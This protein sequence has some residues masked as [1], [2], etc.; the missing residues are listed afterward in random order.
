M[1]SSRAGARSGFYL[2]VKSGEFFGRGGKGSKSGL[3][4]IAEFEEIID[5]IT[6]WA[7]YEG[8]SK[9]GTK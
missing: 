9:K 6:N 8:L 1:P 3:F 2:V 7:K 4:T 5:I